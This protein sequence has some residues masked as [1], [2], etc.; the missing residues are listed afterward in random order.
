MYVYIYE[1]GT[2]LYCCW[3]RSPSIDSYIDFVLFLFLFLFQIEPAEDWKV[4]QVLHWWLLRANSESE[5]EYDRIVD[6]LSKQLDEGKTALWEAHEQVTEIIQDTEIGDNSSNSNGNGNGNSN[7]H[8]QH[9]ENV[10]NQ[11][12]SNN[13]QH[14]PPSNNNIK[15]QLTDKPDSKP[16]AAAAVAVA[17]ATTARPTRNKKVT[18]ITNASTTSTTTSTATAAAANK[19]PDT[20]HIDILGGPY[21]GSFYDLQPKSRSHAWVG[22]SSST[23]FKDR[24]ISLPL[25]LEVS[26]SHGRFEYSK[27]IFYYTDVASTNGSRI[28]G[29][30]CEP[31]RSYDLSTGTMVLAGQTTMKVTL[32]TLA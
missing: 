12:A 13:N 6:G 25:D 30:E 8:H 9:S 11:N 7:S 23:K 18:S 31:N 22:R 14:Q 1:R 27:G 10:E 32:L 26:T 15:R 29:E 28:N 4:E 20:V 5:V 21:D 16:T 19:R 2:V 24:G 3:S 17:V